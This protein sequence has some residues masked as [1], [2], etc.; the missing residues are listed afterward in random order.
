MR[1]GV[2]LFVVFILSSFTYSQ[3]EDI[4]TFTLTHELKTT[5]VKSQ[6]KSGTCWAFAA[7]SFVEAELIRLGY[8]EVD[9]SEMFTVRHKL[10]SMAN[11]YIK[12]HGT[13]NFG[14]GGQAH[15]LMNVISKHGFSFSSFLT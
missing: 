13:S 9:L 4:H 14:E 3:Q 5:S 15:D 12:Y 11:N 7:T 6:G 8:G 10:L 1:K 2:L